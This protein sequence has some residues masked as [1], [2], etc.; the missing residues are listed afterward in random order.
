MRLVLIVCGMLTGFSPLMAQNISEPCSKQR[1]VAIVDAGST[2]SRVHLYTYDLD[3]SN[4]ATNIT[5]R[6]STKV[7]PGLATLDGNQ[8][9]MNAYLDSLFPDIGQQRVPVYFYATAGMR[10]LPQPK[11]QDIYSQV[12]A[13]FAQRSGWNL[14][15]A[16]TITG[17]DE[18]LYGWLSVNYQ[19]GALASGHE[20]AGVLDMGG[21]SVQVSF[22]VSDDDQTAAGNLRHVTLYG[23]R[24]TVFVTSFLGL[25]QTEV[26]HQFMNEATCYA[27]GYLLPNS[28]QAQG[29][30]RSCEAGVTPLINAVHHVDERIQPALRA[31]PVSSWYVMGGMVY[32]AKRQPFSFLNH[33]FTAGELLDK[34]NTEVCQQNWSAL[35][36]RYPG[37]DYLYGDCF[38]AAY[39]YALVVD[40]YGIEANQRMNY[41]DDA[42]SADWPLGVVLANGHGG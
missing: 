25:G 33:Q 2:G 4:S 32:L 27:N 41:L 34:A 26:T 18:G 29:D 8:D 31:H 20:P 3:Q 16:K 42:Q 28:L 5:E 39:Y 24:Y 23:K 14:V 22:P 21:A 17:S 15:E 40:G 12:Q 10:L 38:F 6:W 35:M 13:G 37:D 30:V 1:C 11:Q 9:R 19:T 7:S 36:D